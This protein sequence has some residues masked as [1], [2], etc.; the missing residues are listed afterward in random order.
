MGIYGAAECYEICAG[1]AAE[2]FTMCRTTSRCTLCLMKASP[3]EASTSHIQVLLVSHHMIDMLSKVVGISTVSSAACFCSQWK[4][5]R[6][7]LSK[8]HCWSLYSSKKGSV[9]VLPFQD[10][11]TQIF[12]LNLEPNSWWTSTVKRYWCI[13]KYLFSFLS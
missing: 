12:T 5:L 13:L 2:R 10:I 6:P 11:I 4:K 7:F 9:M 3:D 8:I 1:L